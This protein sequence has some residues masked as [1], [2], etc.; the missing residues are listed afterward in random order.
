MSLREG[1]GE[2]SAACGQHH[3][4]RHHSLEFASL[5]VC[6]QED[7]LCGVCVGVCVCVCV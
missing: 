4:S 3:T 5:E 2:T 6:G 1:K 7:L